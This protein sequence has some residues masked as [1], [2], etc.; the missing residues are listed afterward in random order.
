MSPV[1]KQRP[2]VDASIDNAKALHPKLQAIYLARGIRQSTQLERELTSLLPFSGLLGIDAAAQLLAEAVQQ[3]KHILIVGDF[4]ADG[5]TSSALAVRVLRAFGAAKV[6]FLVP[7]RFEYGSGLTPEMV[8]L[9]AKQ[10]PDLLM[11]VDNGISSIEGVQR[12]KALNM[13]VLITDHH[14]QGD[15]LPEADAIVNPNQN[16]DTFS[17]KNLAGVGVCFYVLLAVRQC[18]KRADWFAKQQLAEPNMGQYLDIVALGT[19]ADVVPLDHNNRILVHQGLRRIRVGR[20]VAGITALLDIAKRKAARLTSADLG[21]AVG[22][23]LNAAGRLDDMRIGIECLLTDDAAIGRQYAQQLDSLNKERREIEQEMKFKALASLERLD[24]DQKKMP[25]GLCLYD[26]NWHQGVIGILASRLKDKYHRPVIVF[27]D[28]NDGEIKG[29]ARSVKS[30]HIRDA[31]DAVTK[32][33]PNL[34]LKFGGHAMAAGLSINKT[35]FATFQTAFNEQIS[36]HLTEQD[37]QGEILTDGSLDY[38]DLQLDFAHLLEDAGPWGQAFPEP[39]F[40]DKFEVIDQRIV[41]K[42]HLKLSLRHK[43]GEKIFSAIQFFTD[44]DSWPNHRCQ[45]VQVVYQLNINE[46]NG[47]SS[48]QFIVKHL[49]PV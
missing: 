3:D 16:G 26:A 7:N 11:T 49:Q 48:V 23:R 28:G 18:L 12:A 5:A 32:K 46:Y 6:S 41:G 15:T 22:P 33:H 25:I 4:D 34:I 29:S 14:L 20:C 39:L 21:F 42:D 30:I 45:Q 31:L 1:I 17:S 10:K 44:L 37:L 47:I 13:K 43:D 36:Q 40:D 8:D 24:F 38:S 9:A 35:D 27:A 2:A 19:V